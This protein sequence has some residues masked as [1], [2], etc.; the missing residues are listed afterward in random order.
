[1]SNTLEQTKKLVAELAAEQPDCTIEELADTGN[2][3]YCFQPVIKDARPTTNTVR[4]F[5]DQL[6][7]KLVQNSLYEAA[8]AT[9]TYSLGPSTADGTVSR[10]YFVQVDFTI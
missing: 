6:N 10:I 3:N 2:N 5:V 7:T 9:A 8:V 1:V 4:D